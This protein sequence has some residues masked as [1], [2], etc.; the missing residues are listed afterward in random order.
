MSAKKPLFGF[1]PRAAV[2]LGMALVIVL[3]VV[4]AKDGYV[5]RDGQP[6]DPEQL[7]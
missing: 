7:G 4:G 5:G 3:V 2:R 6:A 1:L